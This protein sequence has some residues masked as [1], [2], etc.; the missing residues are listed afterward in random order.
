MKSVVITKC[1]GRLHVLTFKTKW[2]GGYMYKILVDV[3]FTIYIHSFSVVYNLFKAS[4][5]T[6]TII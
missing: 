5:I 3:L 2:K 4:D 6:K 1:L